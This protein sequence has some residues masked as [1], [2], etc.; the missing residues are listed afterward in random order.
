MTALSPMRALSSAWHIVVL[1]KNL[2]R[3]T[4]DSYRVIFMIS[5]DLEKFRFFSWIT[6][7]LHIDKKPD[8]EEIQMSNMGS[9]SR[10]LG[11]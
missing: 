4:E 9:N 3:G 10:S 8:R 2:M 6:F 1:D 7:C 11:R 5:I